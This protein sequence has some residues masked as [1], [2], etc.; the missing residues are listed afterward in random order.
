MEFII[1]KKNNISTNHSR[2]SEISISMN[3]EGKI[4]FSFIIPRCVQDGSVPCHLHSH[5]HCRSCLNRG[6]ASQLFKTFSRF[7]PKLTVSPKER[8]VTKTSINKFRSPFSFEKGLSR[9]AWNGIIFHL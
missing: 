1:E 8:Y 5:Y 3:F 6:T 9:N 7:V 2:Q 4:S